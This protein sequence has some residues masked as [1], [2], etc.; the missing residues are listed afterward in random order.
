MKFKHALKVSDVASFLGCHFVGDGDQEVLGLNE[1]HRVEA[2]DL[3]FVDNEKYYDSA[4]NSAATVILI[5]KEVTAPAGKALLVSGQPFLDFNKLCSAYGRRTEWD[6]G[7]QIDAG[8]NTQIH[9]SVVIGKNVTIGSD[10]IIYPGVVIGDNCSIGDRVIIHANCVLGADAFYYKTSDGK[11]EKMLSTGSVVLEDDVELGALC[12]VDRGVSNETRIGS[13]TKIDNHVQVGHD[14]VIGK[15]C[16]FA[17]H[18][19]I[20]GC[21][22]IGNN[23]TAWG[24][25]G[26]VSGLTIGDNVQMLGQSGVSKNIPANMSVVGSPAVLTTEKWREMAAVRGLTRNKKS[27]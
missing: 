27:N 14:T 15:N 22:T 4:L 25:V 7:D 11:H 21:V 20:A 5:D 19:A 1:I 8:R 10:C 2:G 18:V 9:P 26:I 16:R 13:G 6:A 3:V 17:A 12:T 24:Q 23:V